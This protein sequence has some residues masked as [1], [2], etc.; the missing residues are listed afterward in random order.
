MRPASHGGG[1]R[2]IA[3]TLRSARKTGGLLHMWRALRSPNAC[4]TCAFGMGGRRGG[5]VNEAGRFPEVCKKSVQAMAADLHG[6]IQTSVI[7]GTPFSTLERMSPRELEHLGRLTEPLIATSLDDRFRRVSWDE[8]IHR[9]STAVERVDPSRSFYYFSGR[10]SNE[11]GFLLQLC[12]RLRGTSNINNCSYYCHQASGVGL[13]SMTGSG[14]A[15]VVLDDLGKADLVMLIG[16]N[17]ASNHPRF[18]RSLVELRRRGGKV[19]VVNPMREPGLERFKI[20][21]DLRSMMRASRIA[22]LYVQPHVGGDAMFMVG[23][24]KNLI[25][26]GE[27]DNDF[28]RAHTEGWDAWSSR[29]GSCSWEDITSHSGVP[30]EMIDA[31]SRVYAGSKR[32]IFAWAMG[33]T[34][35]VS[36]VRIVQ[37]LGS[38][39]ACRGMLGRPGC[40]LLP[41]R[42]HS[43][44]QGIGSMGVVP[45]LKDAYFDAMQR[46][47]G[48]VFPRDSGLDTMASMEAAHRGEMDLAVCL[49]GN[50]FGSN[51]DSHFAAEAMH[52][53]GTAVHLNTTLNSGHVC[54]R[55][56]ETIILPVLARD[57]ESQPTTQESMFNYVRVSDGG[58]ARHEGPR[59]ETEVVADLFEAALP[60]NGPVDLGQLRSH[61]EIR[62]AI[63]HVVPGYGHVGSVDAGGD[64]FQ[65]EGR[66]FHTPRFATPSKRAIIH[67]VEIPL[68]ATLG[69]H[70]VRVVTVRS[71]GQFNT[72]VYEEEDV[73]RG[74]PRRDAILL[75]REDMQRWRINAGDRVV[76]S[77]DTGSMEAVAYVFD[78]TPG[79]AAMYFPECNIIVPRD[80][81]PIS[82]TPAFKGFVASVR[83]I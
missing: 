11:A 48:D 52:R 33:L 78:I 37:I 54:A 57:E 12:A 9:A 46:R 73:Y 41:L 17:P 69:E 15:T 71:E 42:G 64:E 66:T 29:I 45:L 10:S 50:L 82:R 2:S 14:T 79:N 16:A 18:M 81:D 62:D 35:H 44:V 55:G 22:D 5:M 30:R 47:W 21:S 40:G 67:D 75:S 63:A 83:S 43:N 80:V 56:R 68:P 7:D 39:A 59:G 60:P 27:I 20:P 49:G 76:A 1:W 34:H 3:Y 25:E 72:V 51:P 70:G 26:Q 65:I 61:S 6:G 28:L 24:M 38:L 23:V 32:S 8:A 36:G 77:T 74:I 19:I 58:A 31:V 13:S 4:K 53:I